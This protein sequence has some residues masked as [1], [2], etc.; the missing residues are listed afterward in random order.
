MKR[1][2]KTLIIT[3]ILISINNLIETKTMRTTN[4]QIIP[5]IIAIIAI[6]IIIVIKLN[7]SDVSDLVINR[8]SVAFISIIIITKTH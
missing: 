5:V 7:A 4:N 1:L 6:I 8:I 2:T 3:E